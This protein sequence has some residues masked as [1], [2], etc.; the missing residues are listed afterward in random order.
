[1]A[2]YRRYVI[3]PKWLDSK[4]EDNITLWFILAIL[5]TGFIIEGI[6]DAGH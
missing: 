4:P 2:L 3:K 6:K 5:V 1:M